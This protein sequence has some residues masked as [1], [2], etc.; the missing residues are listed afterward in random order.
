M[1]NAAAFWLF[2]LCAIF[3]PFWFLVFGALYKF[4]AKNSARLLDWYYR[5][6]KD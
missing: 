6:R 2:I 4:L 5:T 1:S 3:F